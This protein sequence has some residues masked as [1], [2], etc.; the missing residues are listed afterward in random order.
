MSATADSIRQEDIVNVEI[1]GQRYKAR[2]GEMIIEAADNAGINIPRFCYHKKLS[3]AANCRMCLVEVEK[4]PKSLPACATPV[5]EGMV[6]FTKSPRAI[7]AQRGT[8]EFLLINHPLDCP[9]CDQGGECDLQEISIGYGSD[10]SEYSETKRV[11]KDKDIGPLISTE[12]TRCIHCTRCVRFGEEVAGI[13]EL[14]ATGRG[15]NMLIGTY[16]EQSMTSELSGNIIDLCPVGAL[17]SKPYRFAARAW[18]VDTLPAI[19]GHDCVGS[20]VNVKTRRNEVMRCDPRENESINEVWISDRDRFSYE[21]CNSE[22]RLTT[23][24]IKVN[25]QWQETDW[26]KALEA[27]VKGLRKVIKSDGADQL[28][29]LVSPSSTVEELYLAQKLTRGLGSNNIDHRLRQQ[30]FSDQEHAPAYPALAINI[31]DIENLKTVMLVGSHVQKDQPIIALRIRKASLMGAKVLAVNPIDYA[32][33]F[34]VTDS[35]VANPVNMEKAL[36]AIAKAVLDK[37]GQSAPDGFDALLTGVE[38]TQQHKAMAEALCADGPRSIFIGNQAM[39]MANSAVIRTLVGLIA[40]ASGATVSI[41]SDGANAAGAWLAGAVPHR[42]VAGESVT[43]GLDA[44]GMLIKPRKAYLTLAI[45]PVLDCANPAQ[46]ATAFNQA[47]YV[48]HMTAYKSEALLASGD[49]LLPITPFTETSGTFVNAEGKWQSFNAAVTALGESRPAWKVLRVLGNFFDIDGFD[50][51]SSDEIRD[52]LAA[53]TA[54]ISNDTVAPWQKIS[55]SDDDSSTLIRMADAPIYV[56][57]AIV[58][59]APALQKTQD[60]QMAYQARMNSDEAARQGVSL[61]A[62]RVEV[63]DDFGRAEF[64][65]VIDD[66]IPDGVIYVPVGTDNAATLGACGAHVQL[67]SVNN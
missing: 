34:D 35:I 14:G 43:S 11:I 8:M 30:D 3:I 50:Y 32:F 33:N 39:M 42:G 64:D 40:K 54:N 36:L 48:V 16:I 1:D 9:I 56:V 57:D 37:T 44:S 6:V 29:V 61:S 12:M 24:M 46:A 13:R 55:L 41:L 26:S 22:S 52:A 53:Q 58:R 21:G 63:S 2:R 10:R 28:G 47:D 60:G 51:V 23:P 19:A 38:I 18:E 25:G 5:T 20:N 59:R 65:L 31:A 4:V 49:V 62:E 27:A 45:E 66:Q 67:E 17:T 15:E 7:E